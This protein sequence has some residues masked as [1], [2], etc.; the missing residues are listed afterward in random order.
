MP[1][2]QQTVELTQALTVDTDAYTAG[3]VVGGLIEL[4]SGN[5][6]GGCLIETLRL[7]DDASQAEPYTVYIFGG[8]TAPDTIAD[9][10]AF[11]PTVADLKK[12]EGTVEITA[13]DYLVISDGAADNDVAIK[14]NL[15]L[16]HFGHKIWIYLVAGD[17]PNYA[18]TADLTL[19]LLVTLDA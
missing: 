10:A 8:A 1:I 11:Q 15:N 2:T 5:P 7:I 3:D 6:G 18:A 14:T 12:L 17:T 9:D 16:R 13:N 19:T 4:D